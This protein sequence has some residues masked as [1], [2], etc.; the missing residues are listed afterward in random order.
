M[1]G[2]S[3]QGHS[4]NKKAS[5]ED[6]DGDG[7]GDG[8]SDNEGGKLQPG[9]PACL[10]P[11]D[12][13]RYYRVSSTRR[14]E[15]LRE[16]LARQL[17]LWT[18]MLRWSSTPAETEKGST[19]S[20]CLGKCVGIGRGVGEMIKEEEED[21]DDDDGD[22]NGDKTE[23]KKDS[24]DQNQRSEKDGS[25]EG[26]PAAPRA[27]AQVE[28]ETKVDD[29]VEALPK[30]NHGDG[31]GK[32]NDDGD[33]DD[34]ME[35]DPPQEPKKDDDGAARNITPAAAE[36]TIA[37][38]DTPACTAAP[39]PGAVEASNGAGVKRELLPID[40]NSN[41]ADG[42]VA[43]PGAESEATAD[44]GGDGAPPSKRARH[45]SDEEKRAAAADVDIDADAKTADVEAEAAAEPQT[46][47]EIGTEVTQAIVPAK[48][49][50]PGEEGAAAT[51]TTN[52]GGANGEAEPKWED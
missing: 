13:R 2:S 24:K 20:S 51:T 50:Q 18:R 37:P 33:G 23:E 26:T 25:K 36:T 9:D 12:G 49:E 17:E 38:L 46:A 34:A 44:D 3:P 11:H 28:A 15:L 41:K 1:L 21:D 22:D 43:T 32:A 45:C 10:N 39:A 5:Q 14:F 42:A 48:A 8:D 52:G 16:V 19:A 35:V 29:K 7:D 4:N 6:G 30:A 47:S 27:Q 31:D 40:I